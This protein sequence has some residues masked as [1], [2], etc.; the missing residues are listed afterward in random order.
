MDAWLIVW[1]ER[2]DSCDD[3][4]YR[5]NEDEAYLEPIIKSTACFAP[6]SDFEPA[7]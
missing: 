3:T 5:D 1:N 2:F 4:I 6:D 7:C